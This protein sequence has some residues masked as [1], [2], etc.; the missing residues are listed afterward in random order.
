MGSLPQASPQAPAHTQLTC[1]QF[2]FLG[3][4][5][6]P[7]QQSIDVGLDLRQLGFDRLQ[8]AALHLEGKKDRQVSASMGFAERG[9]RN[10]AES[11]NE[12][13]CTTAPQQLITPVTALVVTVLGQCWVARPVPRLHAH[14]HT[15]AWP[16]CWQ[17]Q[18]IGR[19]A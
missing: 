8:L 11:S 9:G 16:S 19:R 3:N 12:L 7:A 18:P 14:T 1:G 2:L 13:S 17:W 6:Q 15:S 5:L 10:L 4:L